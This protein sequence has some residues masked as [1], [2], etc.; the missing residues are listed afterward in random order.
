MEPTSDPPPPR[1][2]LFRVPDF[3]RLWFGET[4]SY[5]G[6]QVSHLALPLTA[7]LVLDAGATQMGYLG[8]AEK[9]PYLLFGLLA[10][11][12]V[13][14]ARS[15]RRLLITSHMLSALLLG[16]IPVAAYFG[17][18]TFVQ[19]CAVAF[20]AAS[21]SVVASVAGMAYLPDLVGRDGLIEG[22]AKLTI[23]YSVAQSGGPGLA[24][25]LVQW[26]GAPLAVAAD[27]LSF[28][29]SAVSLATIRRPDAADVASRAHQSTTAS[30]RTG[31]ELVLGNRVLRALVS[32]G[33]LHNFCST[34]IVA[35]FVL[36]A[37]KELDVSPFL[38]GLIVA[39]GGPGAM[40]GATLAPGLSRRIGVGPSISV[41]QV[42]TGLARLLIPLAAVPGSASVALLVVS[43]FALGVARPLFNVNAVSLRQAIAPLHLQ[44]RMNATVRFLMWGVT[45]FGALAGGYLGDVLG[46]R[47]ALFLAVVGVSAATLFTLRPAVREL[48]VV[49]QS[50]ED[51]PE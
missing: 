1:E 27:A 48:R 42:A 40:L 9:L 4:V 16:T 14:R 33:A 19:L 35:V 45:P 24:G 41:A 22:N 36:Y 30:M 15:K 6:D 29:L 21:I 34:M 46:L 50:P 8:A 37:T 39:A 31:L 3:R 32:C 5:V 44:G 13:D 26:L 18:L 2:S 23:S 51:P 11:V 20:A 25:L 43:S 47:P 28:G 10:G 12:L 7:V 49:P 38:L 17:V